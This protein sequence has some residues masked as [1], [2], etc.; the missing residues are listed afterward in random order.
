[1]PPGGLALPSWLYQE[2]KTLHCLNIKPLKC[3]QQFYPS[4]ALEFSYWLRLSPQQ[5]L[6]NSQLSTSGAQGFGASLCS[7]HS[8]AA[9]DSVF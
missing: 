8:M 3:L 6:E 4:S 5:E 7:K 1:M 9:T 2:I